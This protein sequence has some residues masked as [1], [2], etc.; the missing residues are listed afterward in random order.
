VLIHRA[1]GGP[2][3]GQLAFPG[4]VREPGDATLR[5][6]ALREAHEEIGL[7]PENVQI[8]EELEVIE[9]QAT[10]FMIAPYLGRIEPPV[11]WNPQPGE[12]AAILDV[13]VADLLEPGMH[14]TRVAHFPGWPEPRQISYYR[15]G[16][17]ELWGATYRIVH[18]LILRLANDD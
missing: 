16:P 8:I 2:H 13:R 17:H 11:R 1:S 9:T 6:T 10:G 7:P 5:D 12:V 18:P 3:G 4:G 15:I 14:D